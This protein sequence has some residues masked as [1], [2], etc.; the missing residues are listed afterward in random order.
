MSKLLRLRPNQ[1]PLWHRLRLRLA[2]VPAL[3]NLYTWRRPTPPHH[4]HWLIPNHLHRLQNFL[5]NHSPQDMSTCTSMHHSSNL[6]LDWS[7][8]FQLG[9]STFILISCTSPTSSLTLKSTPICDPSSVHL[10]DS[11]YTCPAVVSLGLPL[12]PPTNTCCVYA[13]ANFNGKG[14]LELDELKCD[15]YSSVVSLGDYPIDPSH[16]EYGVA[17]KYINDILDNSIIDSKCNSCEMSDGICGYVPPSNS[18]VCV[19]KNG[20]N[21]TMDCYS[22]NLY[23]QN[24]EQFWG[25][26]SFPTGNIWFGFLASLIF[27]FAV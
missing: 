2:T 5:S 3:C 15:G 18:F 23:G 20:Y 1:V 19:C 27:C 13:P 17:L 9:P 14:E 11:L 8:P 25:T 12:F 24:E 26:A 22:N 6:G 10:C 16:W 7:S 21:T 4:P